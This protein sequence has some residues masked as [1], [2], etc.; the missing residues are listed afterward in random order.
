MSATE[1]CWSRSLDTRWASVGLEI[2][3]T[4]ANETPLENVLENVVANVLANRWNP[5]LT[6]DNVPR[7][8]KRDV[9]C[10]GNRRLPLEGTASLLPPSFV[11]TFYTPTFFM[12]AVAH[13]PLPAW[14]LDEQRDE[15][16]GRSLSQEDDLRGMGDSFN[17]VKAEG[18]GIQ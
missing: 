18:E 4:T 16:D 5:L 1:P 14:W 6:L 8:H 9:R 12:T 17:D 11:S 13:R 7:F 10:P 3:R 2:A 15:I